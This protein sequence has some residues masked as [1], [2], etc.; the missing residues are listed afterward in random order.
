MDPDPGC[1]INRDPHGSGSGSETLANTILFTLAKP[2]KAE[3]LF[4]VE[5]S[6]LKVSFFFVKHV[7]DNI[8][9]KDIPSTYRNG[10]PP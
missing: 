2:F 3:K 10:R 5:S 9:F 7:H 4:Y 6:F 8:L 1:E